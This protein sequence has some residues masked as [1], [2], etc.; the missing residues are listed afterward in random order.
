MPLVASQYVVVVPVRIHSDCTQLVARDADSCVRPKMPKEPPT[1]GSFFT[2]CASLAEH[3][4]PEPCCRCVGQYFHRAQQH[5]VVLVI[6]F[7][8]SDKSAKQ[9]AAVQVLWNSFR[10]TGAMEEVDVTTLLSLHC[11]SGTLDLNSSS[12]LE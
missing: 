7:L 12:V 4:L 8:H 11:P 10:P 1:A 3:L 5:G 2:I 9:H 6:C